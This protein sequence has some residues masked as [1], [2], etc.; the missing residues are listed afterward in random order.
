V[1]RLFARAILE[2][3]EI[4]GKQIGP[5]REFELRSRSFKFRNIWNDD[6]IDPPKRFLTMIKELIL[7]RS[8]R[9]GGSVPVK[10]PH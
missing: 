2:R 4:P 5:M 8:P 9:L 7:E 10:L 3:D 6:G 1:K